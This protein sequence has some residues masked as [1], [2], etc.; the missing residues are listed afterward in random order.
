MA[1]RAGAATAADAVQRDE[2]WGGSVSAHGAGE[3]RGR[4]TGGEGAEVVVTSALLRLHGIPRSLA[5]SG[6]EGPAPERRRRRGERRPEKAAAA[7]GG[8]DRPGRE[9]GVCACVRAPQT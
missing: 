7:A 2:R 5:A 3:C 1:R 8:G 4:A 9:D 6:E